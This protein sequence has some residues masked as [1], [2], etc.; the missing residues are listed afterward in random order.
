MTAQ[1]VCLSSIFVDYFVLVSDDQLL[2]VAIFLFI[3]RRL[4]TISVHESF[5]RHCAYIKQEGLAVASI[6]RDVEITPPRKNYAR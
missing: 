2:V 3:C 4:V 6:A 5:S 1:R